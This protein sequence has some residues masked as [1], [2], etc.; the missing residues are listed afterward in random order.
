MDG[1][2]AATDVHMWAPALWPAALEQQRARP[3]VDMVRISGLQVPGTA[4]H[5]MSSGYE[6]GRRVEWAVIHDLQANGYETTRA[7]SSKGA[8]DVIAI[9]AG[10]VLLVNVKRTTPPGPAERAELLRIAAMLP[11]VCIPLVA[12]RPLREPLRYRR[13]IGSRPQDWIA[14]APDFTTE[15]A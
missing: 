5:V 15:V 1:D 6:D 12:L 7:A 9:K 2:H 14:W 3:T 8:A 4:A 11:G 10:Q 13:L